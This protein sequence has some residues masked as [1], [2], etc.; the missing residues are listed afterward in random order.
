MPVVRNKRQRGRKKRQEKIETSLQNLNIMAD[1]ACLWGR[2]DLAGLC[3]GIDS[4]GSYKMRRLGLGLG[5]GLFKVYLREYQFKRKSNNTSVFGTHQTK[6]IHICPHTPLPSNRHYWVRQVFSSYVHKTGN[7]FPYTNWMK[8]KTSIYI[9]IL[10]T[11]HS[12]WNLSS[13]TRAWTQ[14]HGSES[15][16]S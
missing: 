8:A 10:V 4:H 7:I 11:P 5:L 6:A 12:L 13:L 2:W 3:F 9:Y 1:S 14:G 15:T 16:V